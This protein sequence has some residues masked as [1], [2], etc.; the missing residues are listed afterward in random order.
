MEFRGRRGSLRSEGGKHARI[1]RQESATVQRQAGNGVMDVI[2]CT[3][4]LATEESVDRYALAGNYIFSLWKNKNAEQRKELLQRIA[5]DQLQQIGVPEIGLAEVPEVQVGVGTRGG[6]DPERWEMRLPAALLQQ[7]NLD[8]ATEA[9]LLGTMAHESR[10]AE[11][12]Y[13]AARY[14]AGKGAQP[15]EVSEQLRIRPDVAQQAAEQTSEEAS[16]GEEAEEVRVWEQSLNRRGEKR[17]TAE[18]LAIYEAATNQKKL[19]AEVETSL[20]VIKKFEAGMKGEENEI[21]KQIYAKL[22]AEELAAVGPMVEKAKQIWP[23]TK[24]TTRSTGAA[25]RRKTR[26]K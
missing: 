13:L 24:I 1:R 22:I 3:R 23:T 12:Y 14:L 18:M 26:G 9:K 7:Q 17:R 16:E 20:Q 6:F 2:Q 25:Q 21:T 10:H 5:N 15:E 19:E 4:G 8:E 11:Q